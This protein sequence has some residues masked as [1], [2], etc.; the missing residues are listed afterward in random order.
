[1]TT[2]DPQSVIAENLAT[3][4]RLSRQETD[5]KWLEGMT[6]VVG[7]HLR[8]W[9]LSDCDLWDEWEQREAFFP[10][11]SKRDVGIDAVGRRRSDG[12]AVAI[13]CKSRKLDEQGIGGSIPKDEIDSFASSSSIEH[14]AERWLVTNGANPATENAIAIHEYGV[15]PIKLVNI[16]SDMRNQQ[17]GVSQEDCPHCVDS[18]AKQTKSCMQ[19]EAIDS[20]VRILQEHVDSDSGGLPK[21]QARGRIVL[22]C[23]TG[24][25]RISLRIV[26]RLTEPGELSIV[27]C[28]SIALVAQIRRE[29]LQHAEQP[30]RV[31]AVCSDQ[32]AGYDPKQ[33]DKKVSSDDPTLDKSNVRASAVKGLVTTNPDVIAEWIQSE[34]GAEHVN[35]I[36]GTYQSGS[37]IA[38]AL[39]LTNSKAQVMI[40]DEAHR[41]A[42]LKRKS[43][44][45]TDEEQRLRDFTL[46]HDNDKFPAVYRVYQ[47]ATPRIYDV[48]PQSNTDKPS[49]WVV[50]TMDDEQ[51]F[52]V[53]LY[54]KS[55]VEAVNNDWLSDYRIIAL[56]INDPDSYALVNQL[57]QDTRS[58]GRRKLTA[59][60]YLRGLAF[61]LAMGGATHTTG[62]N[63][64]PIQSCIA[65]MNTVDKSKNMA[66]DLQTNAVRTWLNNWLQENR[67][68]AKDNLAKGTPETPQ[69]IFNVGIFG[70]GTDSPSLSAV[71]F[72]EARRSPIDV[73]QAVGRAMRTS[74]GKEVGYIICPIVIPP[75]A[76]PENW[77]ASS[78]PEEGWQELGQILRALRAHD[79]RIEDNLADLMELHIPPTPVEVRTIVAI[80]DHEKKRVEY[81]EHIG[82]VGEA[83]YALQQVIEGKSTLSREFM[84]IAEQ[85]DHSDPLEQR[86]GEPKTNAYD[87]AAPL[88][89]TQVLAAK[90]H[91]DGSIEMRLGS[92]ARSKP[93]AGDPRGKVDVPKTKTKA[94]KMINDGTGK[95]VKTPV[96]NPKEKRQRRSPEEAAEQSMMHTL[97]EI[98]LGEHGNAI[99]MNLL[100]K[101][102]L[103]DNRVVRDLNI[104]ESSVKEAAFH[105]R[106]D[107]LGP[108]LDRHFGLH[109]LKQDDAKKQADGCTIAA[110]LMMNAAMLHQRIAHG[111]W[112]TGVS[113]LDQVKNDVNVVR[114]VER[115]WNRI[116]RHDFRPV[117]EPAVAVIETVDTQGKLSGLERALRHIAAEAE[118]IAETYA[119]MGADH[120]GPLFNKV[121]GNQAS[122]G[123]YFTRPTAA[124]LAARL[125]LDACGDVD[126]TDPQ[127]W[128]EHKTVDLACGS[129]TLLAAILTEMKRRAREQGANEDE[130]VDLQKLAVEET[131][132]GLD[133]NPVSLQLAASQLTAGNREIRYRQMGLHLMPYGPSPDNPAVVQAGTLELLGQEAI[134]AR[135]T[136]LGLGD[137]RISSQLVWDQPDDAELEDAVGAV[138]EARIVIMNPP[139]TNRSKVGEKFQSSDRILLLARIDAMAEMLVRGDSRLGGFVD[140]NTVAPPFVG[141]ADRILRSHDSVLTVV[142]PTIALSNP[143]GLQERLVLAERF[144]IHTI[145]TCHQP[146]QINLSQI[147]NINE[148]LIIA[149]RH[150]EPQPPTR[151]I[152]LDRFPATD[153]QVTDLHESLARCDIGAIDNGWGEV[154]EWPA[155]RVAEGDWT[156]AIW[157]SPE[158]AEAASHFATDVE[159]QSIESDDIYQAG[160]RVREFCR[161]ASDS[162]IDSFPLLKSKGADGQTTIHA[163]PDSHYRPK[164]PTNRRCL[165]GV[166]NLKARAEYLLITDGQDSSSARLTA[167]A[168]DTRY[169]G[170]GWMPLAGFTPE[171]AKALSV[172]L[173]STPG[174][175]Q[176]MRNAGRKLE[177]PMYMPAAYDAVRI[178]DIRDG[179]IRRVLADCWGRTKGEIV[180]QFRDGECKVRQ[181]WDEA[182]AEAMGWDP[183]EL[184]RLRLLLHREPHVRGLGYNQYADAGESA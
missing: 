57:A 108:T 2:E 67:D 153:D 136:E 119:D 14:F 55:Y 101:S 172:F 82:P 4:D 178:P 1:M 16:V 10:G 56:G 11:L 115:E 49:D 80:A 121:M 124:S 90:R 91:E 125:T 141:L 171:E 93:K 182:V 137:D 112:L 97:R 154:S 73:I 109:N 151:F 113:D 131:I 130:L 148:S 53:E 174:R 63:A 41:T 19:D 36:F 23:G 175:L 51:V 24:K 25:T 65:F 21:G 122:D 28:P 35:V 76:D 27:L 169:V 126:W 70:E 147:V 79:S 104:L 157:R 164:E 100:S 181:L 6:A 117:L 26:E 142:H 8:E 46:C 15:K 129:G 114:R 159:M 22:P 7:E 3:A 155:T 59:S 99:R 87:A 84:S 29:Y 106:Q 54:R 40:A 38:E 48:K 43:K 150:P 116:M 60:D 78:G 103:T 89:P 71:A 179:R 144:H 133:I 61:T 165:R 39:Q 170:E 13:Q 88:E 110:L 37:R 33:E 69:G 5:G 152:N 96:Q 30:L 176:L 85:D 183:D 74:P 123:A 98:G 18:S 50:R 31:L 12:R 166:Q 92:P 9:D 120:A 177:F 173:N 62:G 34:Q 66:R 75:N 58:K 161:K 20:S 105:L 184:T 163:M 168:S 52:G 86:V 42:G 158:L 102:G 77:L 156:P 83:E 32:T 45:K 139:F 47:T 72:L 134:V 81:R 138:K 167:V 146:G 180:P 128:R 68:N 160:R 135:D 162:D 140:K 17:A 44:P 143:S 94:R 95:R 149:R 145:V 64:V 111:R 127:V 132:K 118:R 107:E